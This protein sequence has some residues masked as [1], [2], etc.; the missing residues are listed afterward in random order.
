MSNER[1][2]AHGRPRLVA[3]LLA[4]FIGFLAGQLVA[5]LLESLG[6]TLAHFRGGLGALVALTVPPWW[7]NVLGLV[8]LWI[9]FS[10]A[11]AY[12]Y[13]PGGLRPWVNQWRFRPSDVGYLALGPLLQLG[14]DL[15][16][17]PF[18]L[19]HLDQPVKHLFNGSRG[20][21]F[22]LVGVLT[23]VVAPFFE[24]WFFRG[25]IYRALAEG[26]EVR[27]S[28]LAVIVATIGSAALFAAAHGEP[29]Q[30]AGL[31][32]LGVVLATLVWRTHRLTP[33]VLT[34][35]SFNAAAFV[36]VVAQ[37]AGHG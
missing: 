6:A 36:A 9:G 24:E 7:A 35:A 14:V 27:S 4:S 28:R 37:R 8:G 26:L 33:S 18:H 3:I 22:V 29:A 19:R 12:A 11:I 23:T 13:G 10:G 2:N 32:V 16:Y 20:A 25:V 1:E 31:F 15:A 5:S 17:R 21:T 30:F 34:H